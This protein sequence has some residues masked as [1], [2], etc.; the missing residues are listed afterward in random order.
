MYLPSLV[1]ATGPPVY[2]G[3]KDRG[4]ARNLG[5]KRIPLSI[6]DLP[7]KYRLDSGTHAVLSVDG[8]VDMTASLLSLISE[9]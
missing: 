6:K 2:V 8:S 5:M 1:I 3:C 4:E 9:T 7:H